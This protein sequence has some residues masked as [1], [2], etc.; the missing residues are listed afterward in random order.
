MKLSHDVIQLRYL[1]L[2]LKLIYIQIIQKKPE[3][4]EEKMA[5]I[6]ID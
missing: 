1:A 5:H 6:K 3:Q 4:I 2:Y